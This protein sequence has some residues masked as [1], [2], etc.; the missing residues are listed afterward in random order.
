MKNKLIPYKRVP[1]FTDS[2]GICDLDEYNESV[3]QKVLIDL[4]GIDY[5]HIDSPKRE[6]DTIILEELIKKNY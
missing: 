1:Y 4:F 6:T 2:E 5:E 3:S